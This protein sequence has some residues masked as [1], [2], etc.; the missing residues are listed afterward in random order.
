MKEVTLND[1][2]VIDIYEAPLLGKK[3]PIT[4]SK[5]VW[6][7]T[8]TLSQWFTD[9]VDSY[10]QDDQIHI[11]VYIAT[12]HNPEEK[13]YS[14][15]YID[16][17]WYANFKFDEWYLFL[18]SMIETEYVFGS[19]DRKNPLYI[20]VSYDRIHNYLIFARQDRYYRWRNLYHNIAETK[21]KTKKR[22][23]YQ[24]YNAR[25]TF[26]FIDQAGG[27]HYFYH[28]DGIAAVQRYLKQQME[29]NKPQFS[30]REKTSRIGKPYSFF[31]DDAFA[32]IVALYEDTGFKIEDMQPYEI[33]FLF[34]PYIWNIAVQNSDNIKDN[35][36][37][38]VKMLSPDLYKVFD[39]TYQRYTDN[40]IKGEV[41]KQERSGSD[42]YLSKI[43][44]ENK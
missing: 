19:L 35:A 4:A 2:V 17:G 13:I 14:Q 11:D 9:N 20:H 16:A 18:R 12:K 40:M 21:W 44:K 10:E 26:V 3:K 37:K 8:E 39:L 25:W 31:T 34:A 23:F 22:L 38:F 33:K 32:A 43:K 41:F 1:I 27:Y 29:E 28:P 24:L 6:R 36:K 15:F 30:L 5:S 7:A 42:F